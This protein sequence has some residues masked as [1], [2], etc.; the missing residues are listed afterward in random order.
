MMHPPQREHSWWRRL[1]WL[2]VIWAAGVATLGVVAWGIRCLM[3]A[4]G[5]TS[6]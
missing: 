3:H 4:A 1:A 2:V 5:L 6:R